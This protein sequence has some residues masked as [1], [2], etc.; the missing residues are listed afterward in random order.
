PVAGRAS[1]E[2][3]ARSVAPSLAPGPLPCAATSS[4]NQRSLR[5][6]LPIRRTRTCAAT[7]H[8]AQASTSARVVQVSCPGFALAHS[9]VHL[10]LF[11]GQLFRI[12]RLFVDPHCVF[13]SRR[14]GRAG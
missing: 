11:P 6:S 7:L 13:A 9:S 12:A 10:L 3:H 14:G 1:A 8:S 4:C 5:P 2:H